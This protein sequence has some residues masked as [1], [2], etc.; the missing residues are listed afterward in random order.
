MILRNPNSSF[1]R[2]FSSPS[3][4]SHLCNIFVL[5]QVLSH[6][7]PDFSPQLRA[8]VERVNPLIS[9]EVSSGIHSVHFLIFDGNSA[10]F[11]SCT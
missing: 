2:A 9:F 1:S 10:I 8:L 5:S 4:F 11:F 6:M 3:S 7:P